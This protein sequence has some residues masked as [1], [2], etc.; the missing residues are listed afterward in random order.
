LDIRQKEVRDIQYI[1]SRVIHSYIL[2]PCLDERGLSGIFFTSDR[3]KQSKIYWIGIDDVITVF[4]NVGNDYPVHIEYRLVR[5]QTAAGKDDD[6][7]E[8]EIF[9]IS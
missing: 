5:P 8:K 6:V 7:N 4:N 1:S 9:R 2:F 3:D